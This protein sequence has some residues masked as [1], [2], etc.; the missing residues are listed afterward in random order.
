MPDNLQDL[1]PASLSSRR[2][3]EILHQKNPIKNHQVLSE[4][5]REL[6][7]RHTD[8]MMAHWHEPH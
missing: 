3:C 4:I 5:K 8:T 2:L 7:L 6:R 1:K